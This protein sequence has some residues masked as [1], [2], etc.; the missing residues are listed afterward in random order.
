MK[1]KDVPHSPAYV[2]FHDA[3]MNGAMD[4]WPVATLVEAQA[5]ADRKQKHLED[6]GADECGGYT[7][8]TQLPRKRVWRYHP[9]K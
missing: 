8:Y 5:I 7:A 4:I 3:Y 1:L 2:V 6:E 9:A